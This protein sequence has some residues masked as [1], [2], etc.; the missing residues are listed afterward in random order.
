MLAGGNDTECTATWNRK[1]TA[2]ATTTDS[3]AP[4]S[5]SLKVAKVSESKNCELSSVVC[6]VVEIG[7]QAL[8]R[9]ITEEQMVIAHFN[10]LSDNPESDLFNSALLIKTGLTAREAEELIG[11]RDLP[12]KM[13]YQHDSKELF[14]YDL[15][16]A[17][18]EAIVAEV[19]G[20]L[21]NFAQADGER[22]RVTH[23]TLSLD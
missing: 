23:D 12:F 2:T 20:Q 18:H 6:S 17:I 14:A 15:K 16:S 19:T 3:D 7:L 10:A 1:A 9:G 21:A 8:T 5:T 13:Y 4:A 11:R 22:V